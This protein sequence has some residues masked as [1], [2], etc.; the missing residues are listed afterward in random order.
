MALSHTRSAVLTRFGI[1]RLSEFPVGRFLSS[2]QLTRLL[3]DPT[4]LLLLLHTFRCRKKKKR[5]QGISGT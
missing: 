2:T 4:L 3:L 5:S 1:G